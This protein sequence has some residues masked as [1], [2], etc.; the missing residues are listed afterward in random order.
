MRP[1]NQKAAYLCL[2]ATQ[3][4][5]ASHAHVH[6]IIKGLTRRGW[7]IELF[8]PTYRSLGALVPWYR[9]VLPLL[10]AQLRLW[11][12]AR[13]VQLVYIRAHPAAFPT[14]I[15]AAIR[16]IPVI[17]EINGPLEE[18]TVVYPWMRYFRPLVRLSVKISLG[19]A[20][21]IIAVTPQLAL[22]AE[23]FSPERGVHVVP[24]GADTETF[25]PSAA[26]PSIRYPYAI[27]FGSLTKWQG[28]PTLLAAVN[29]PEWPAG[30]KLVVVGDGVERPAVERAAEDNPS[31]VYMGKQPYRDMP[32][33][34]AGSLCGLVPKT[35]IAGHS[36]S[37]LSPLKLYETLACGV[38]AVVSDMPGLAEFVVNGGCG[39]V[40]PPDDPVALA[41]AV[42]TVVM[43]GSSSVQQMGEKARA[44]VEREHSWDSRAAQTDDILQMVLR[45]STGEDVESAAS[46]PVGW[47][48]SGA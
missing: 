34:I 22:W 26:P 46:R 1:V 6:E 45:E 39:F 31:L 44:L 38:P 20:K 43:A 23:R 30:V 28:I 17:Q 4:G 16:R 3:E 2:E 14:A 11:R 33:L 7:Q 13:D 25:H 27:F 5:Q 10:D 18:V 8:G 37:G 12:R 41:K 9:K 24:N 42:A 36:S 19:C 15:W 29:R 47:T 48:Q 21:A 32:A 35:N 40:V